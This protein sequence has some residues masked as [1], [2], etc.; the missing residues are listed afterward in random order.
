MEEYDKFWAAVV[1]GDETD[2]EKILEENPE[3]DVNGESEFG[4]TPLHYACKEG[5]DEIVSLLLDHPA[6]EVNK[7]DGGRTPFFVACARG[8]VSLVCLLLEDSRVEINEPM[9]NGETALHHACYY[10][11]DSV[12]S[13]LLAHPDIEVNQ[14]D[15]VQRTPFFWA[16]TFFRENASCVQVLL[17][18]SRVL[19]NEPDD[20]GTT[21][22]AVAAAC[23]YLD[24]IKWW[25]SS[26]RE[27]DLGQPGNPQTDAIGEGKR[28]ENTEIV[29]LLE[30]FKAH[31]TLTRHQV[32]VELEIPEQMAA[33]TFSLVI[34]L[35]DGL[36]EI[37]QV[38]QGEVLAK[39]IRFFKVASALPLELQ[40]ILCHYYVGSPGDN[41]A[42]EDSEGSFLALATRIRSEEK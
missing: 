10:G 38:L 29:S 25:I 42:R 24:I 19:V 13:V 15:S 34:F 23:G 17:E 6:I 14:K 2:L 1:D 30:R 37:S 26:G 31:P 8:S 7:K 16:C 5:M 40:M 35:C 21:P 39:A 33:E 4:H 3:I 12:V 36:F 18:D 32:R 11:H 27:I 28:K 22:L 9:E 20:E 41:I